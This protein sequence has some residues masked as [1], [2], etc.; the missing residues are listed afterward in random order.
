M[1]TCVNG[2]PIRQV[3]ESA[4]SVTILGSCGSMWTT[5]KQRRDKNIHCSCGDHVNNNDEPF[6]MYLLPSASAKLIEATVFIERF[7]GS[8]QAGLYIYADASSW[9]KLVLEG[10]GM[11]GAKL[12][13]AEELEGKPFVQ[14]KHDMGN[15]R[16]ISLRLS[17][18]TDTVTAEFRLPDGPWQE[19]TRGSGWNA[20][21]MDCG[22]RAVCKLPPVWSAA[23]V[24]EQWPACESAPRITFSG[25]LSQGKAERDADKADII[26][27]FRITDLNG[28]GLISNVE[29]MAV[30]KDLFPDWSQ[31]DLNLLFDAAAEV[32]DGDSEHL[33][34]TLFVE[35]LQAVHEPAK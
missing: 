20:T 35:W 14:G 29:C 10:N 9:V 2:S 1:T 6:N 22:L 26:Q 30:F 15:A 3:S 13:F 34:Y 8:G 12:I 24:S 19:V 5:Q 16:T 25:F 33:D 23:L 28:D 31:D 4:D 7:V 17:L 32:C 21:D 27:T 11:G 18:A